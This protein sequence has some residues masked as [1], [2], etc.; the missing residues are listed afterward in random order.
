[1]N[2]HYPNYYS[3]SEPPTDSQNPVPINFL[4]VE[5]TSFRF[6]FLAKKQGLLDKLK[7]QF[8]D[9]LEMKGIGA[10]TAVGYGYFRNFED[11]TNNIIDTFKRKTTS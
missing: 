3:G 4:T 5:K 11:Q 9:V 8:E 10:K 7:A 1:M 6:V 2:P